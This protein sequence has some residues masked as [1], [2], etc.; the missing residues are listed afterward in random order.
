M[1]EM[2]FQE[3]AAWVLTAITC[4]TNVEIGGVAKAINPDHLT[5]IEPMFAGEV[6]LAAAGQKMTRKQAG[7]IVKELLPKYEDKIKG[8]P[9]LT[10]GKKYQELYNMDSLTPCSEYVDLYQQMKKEIGKLG[11]KFQYNYLK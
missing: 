8:D 1:T 4:G 9:A 2:Y 10:I 5:P 3:A 7:D 6:A 11:V